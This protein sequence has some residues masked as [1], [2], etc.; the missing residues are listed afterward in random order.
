[1]MFRIY[2][3]GRV[4][5]IQELDKGLGLLYSCSAGHS[6]PPYL[7]LSVNPQKLVF[8]YHSAVSAISAVSTLFL[9][10]YDR[11][12]SAQHGIQNILMN[13][14]DQHVVCIMRRIW[15][16]VHTHFVPICTSSH[17]D[18]HTYGFTAQESRLMSWATQVDKRW[19]L[20]IISNSTEDC[21]VSPTSA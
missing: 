12:K 18:I 17:S 1:M 19:N 13:T 7:P 21:K 14:H 15:C 6:L 5:N 9:W 8:W 2:A 3:G 10:P 16:A 11:A 20:I 4:L